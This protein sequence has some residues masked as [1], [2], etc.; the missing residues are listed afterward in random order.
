MVWKCGG[1]YLFGTVS[2]LSLQEFESPI[3]KLPLR[4]TKFE[5]ESRV[6]IAVQVM[7]R[8][9]SQNDGAYFQSIISHDRS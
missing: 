2:R 4:C 3:V 8:S 6:P 7:Q 1:G 9:I 5:I